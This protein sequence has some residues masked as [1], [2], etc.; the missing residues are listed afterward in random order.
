MLHVRIDMR[1]GGCAASSQNDDADTGGRGS[2]EFRPR[3][4]YKRYGLPDIGVCTRRFEGRYIWA[5]PPGSLRSRSS[6]TDTFKEA[7]KSRGTCG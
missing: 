4:C 1:L 7:L 6:A 3:V 2:Q 5:G